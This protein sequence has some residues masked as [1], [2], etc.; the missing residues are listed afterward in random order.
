M[1][2]VALAVEGEPFAALTDG[3]EGPPVLLLHGFP[4]V[5]RAWAGVMTRLAARGHRAVAPWMRGYRPSPVAGPFDVDRLAADVI[6]LAHAISP[7]APVH[8]VGHDWGAAVAYVAATRRPDRVATLATL[9]VPHPLTLVRGIATDPRQLARSAYMGFFQLPWLPERALGAGLVEGLYRAWSPG[10]EVPRAHLDE[11]RACLE[12]SAYAPL[13]YY[14]AI[15][16][17][18][19]AALA[20]LREGRAL[21]VPVPTLYLHGADDGCVRA[22]LASRQ[23]ARFEGRL[24]IEILEGAGHFLPLERPAHVATRIAAWIAEA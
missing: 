3:D 1:R 23:R 24:E 14:R 16:R 6:A 15:T 7:D 9:S 11:V 21:R 10:L 20:R 22:A 17:P 5:P 18:P 12:D 13:E 2:Q 8:L 19:R 4:D